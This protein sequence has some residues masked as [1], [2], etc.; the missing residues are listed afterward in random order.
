MA[1]KVAK[2]QT[3]APAIY[4]IGNASSEIHSVKCWR[5]HGTKQQS[6]ATKNPDNRY[7]VGECFHSRKSTKKAVAQKPR[8]RTNKKNRSIWS[9]FYCTKCKSE[10][11]LH[12]KFQA[13]GMRS[14]EIE[15]VLLAG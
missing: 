7:T 15:E 14:H 13:I 9:G 12:G 10:V 11:F 3:T 6:N 5:K 2:K 8:R 4:Y 1:A